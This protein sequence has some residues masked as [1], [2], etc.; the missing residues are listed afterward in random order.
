MADTSTHAPMSMN[1]VI[2]S[3]FRRDLD[4]FVDALGRF[5]AGNAT[6]ATQLLTAWR[7]FNRQLAR[8]HEGEHEIAWP[9]LAKVGVTA[10]LLAELDAEHERMAEAL[11]SADAAMAALASSATA[12]EAA[13]ARDAMVNLRTVTDEHLRHEEAEIEPVY[14]S[15]ADHPAIKEM[16]RRFARISPPVAGEFFA[17]LGDGADSTTMAAMS[18]NVPKPVTTVLGGVFGRGYRKNVAPVWKS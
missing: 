17:W 6:R 18:A 13:K 12:A 15:N 1:R 4:R 3:A 10:E 9:A 2:H 16:G 11:A 8:H 14:L 7:H 5:P